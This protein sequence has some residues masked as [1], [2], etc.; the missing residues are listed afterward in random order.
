MIRLYM[1]GG[2][3]L[4]PHGGASDDILIGAILADEESG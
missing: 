2:E 3:C 4:T 1:A